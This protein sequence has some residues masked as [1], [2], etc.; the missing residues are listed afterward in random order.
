[1]SNHNVYG[2]GHISPKPGDHYQTRNTKEIKCPRC[3]QIHR[4]GTVYI[5]RRYSTQG[6]YSE[7]DPAMDC[8]NPAIPEDK[9][10]LP[11][12][13]PEDKP[14]LKPGGAQARSDALFNTHFKPYGF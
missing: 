2:K 1:M 9:P 14:P 4:I 10:P 3:G 11:S 13:P 6:W 8:P 7:F 5:T 12:A